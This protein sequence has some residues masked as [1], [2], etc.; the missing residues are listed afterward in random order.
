M[1][2]YHNLTL[3]EGFE[4]K[5]GASKLSKLIYDTV[6]VVYTLQ[7]RTTFIH[8]HITV[9]PCTRGERSNQTL[10]EGLYIMMSSRLVMHRKL[11]KQYQF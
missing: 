9:G 4:V 3:K 11:Q 8:F 5:S 10:S 6:L 2:E 7:K 1:F